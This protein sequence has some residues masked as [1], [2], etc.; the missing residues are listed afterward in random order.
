[1]WFSLG[2]KVWI[3]HPL[4]PFGIFSG[5]SSHGG[6]DDFQPMKSRQW[7][8]G[9]SQDALTNGN[10]SCFITNSSILPPKELLHSTVS[11]WMKQELS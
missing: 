5:L 6:G 9:T 2:V 10:Y 7:R 3:C 11:R 1:M 8:A 4:V